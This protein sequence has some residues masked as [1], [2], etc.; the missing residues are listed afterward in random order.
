M[1]EIL[2]QIFIILTFIKFNKAI[3]GF[4]CGSADPAVKIYSLVDTGECD[5]MKKIYKYPTTIELLQLAEFK[6]NYV[7]QCKIEINAECSVT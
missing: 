6:I 7:I 5:F 2:L 1:E 3:I 4:N